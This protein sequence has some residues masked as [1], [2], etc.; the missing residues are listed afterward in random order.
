MKEA[1]DFY[2]ENSKNISEIKESTS[3]WEEYILYSWIGRQF[4]LIYQNYPL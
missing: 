3:K 2:T 1:K 4:L